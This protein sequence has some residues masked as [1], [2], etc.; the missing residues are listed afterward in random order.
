MSAEV[1]V[2][3]T[4]MCSTFSEFTL[5]LPFLSNHLNNNYCTS[6]VAAFLKPNCCIKSKFRKAFTQFTENFSNCQ[7]TAV[8]ND[9]LLIFMTYTK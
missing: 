8:D 5:Y 3:K 4:K 9:I 7:A 6:S 1:K 2:V